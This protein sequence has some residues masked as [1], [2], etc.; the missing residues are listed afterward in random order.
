[1]N[2]PSA[3]FFTRFAPLILLAVGGLVYANSF[4]VP[5]IYDDFGA[6]VDNADIR[7]L[8]PPRWA[9]PSSAPN[10]PT[11]SRPIVAFTLALNY[12]LGGS[13]ITGYRLLNIG[14]HILCACTL[15]TV[16]RRTLQTPSLASRFG[17]IAPH[18]ALACALLW[19]V[20][21]LG[22]QC[23]DYTIQRSES[24]MAL[25]YLLAL[26]SAIRHIETGRPIWSVIAVLTC[27]LGM[28][29]KEAMV[30]APLLILLYD[31]TYAAGSFAAAWNQRKFLYIGLA[32]TWLFLAL[33]MSAASHGSSIGFTSDVTPLDYALN[34][35]WIILDYLKKAVWPHPLIVD[36]G[37]PLPL[38]IGDVLPQLLLLAT[39]LGFTVVALF[40]WP[41]LAFPVVW[42]FL[43]LAPT[44]S[45][46][47]IVNEVGAERRIYLPL[48]GLIILAVVAG[49]LLLRRLR[50][51]AWTGPVLLLI[52]ITTFGLRTAQRNAEYRD[53]LDLWQTAIDAVPHNPR[54]HTYLG[55][56]LKE[57]GRS[58]EAAQRY[59]RALQ[60]DPHYSEAHANLGILLAEAGQFDR[61][62]AHFRQSLDAYPD[63]P[64]VHNNLGNA[65]LSSGR[66]D[67]ALSSFQRALELRPH[68]A[69]AHSNLGILLGMQGR[70]D[71]A[72]DRF[73][74]ALEFDPTYARAHFNL[75]ITYMNT[76]ATD[77][78]VH[79]FRQALRFQPDFPQARRGLEDA[80]RQQRKP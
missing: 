39:L 61:A 68:Y 11:N 34:Q 19:L 2:P 21:P 7:R 28:A 25:F 44:S 30:T 17:P 3:T 69:D 75:G 27:A 72:I 24:L 56:A 43:I 38:T 63:Y 32:S 49:H 45:I 40:R 1:M 50:W 36:Y 62:I 73:H 8:W 35:S 13:S 80:L 16:A 33:L 4:S 54:A 31:R 37:Y 9:L 20:H 29:S 53:P 65:L 57:R 52:L 77:K 41:T 6:I 46:V 70:T 55:L 48:A 74:R 71:E 60:L 59:Q 78:A 66:L 12:A 58:S 76:A 79:H 22:T 67:L 14:V 42:F 47:P 10:A 64:E 26:Y 5:F 18:L 15:F 51:P 23:V